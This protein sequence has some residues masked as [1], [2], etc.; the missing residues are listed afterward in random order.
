LFALNFA[1]AALVAAALVAPVQRLPGV[2]GRVAVPLLSLA[3][4]GVA[5]G[6][7]AG[8][9]A[10]ETTGLF[11]FMEVGYRPA[12]L[13]SLGLEAITILLL[14]ASCAATGSRMAPARR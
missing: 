9:L 2:A 6:S 7:I 4:I 1:A 3:G 11:G 13:L 10:S 5:A 8:L 12:I 14:G